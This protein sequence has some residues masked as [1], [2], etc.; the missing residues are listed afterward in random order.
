MYAKDLKIF[1][2]AVFSDICCMNISE[3]VSLLPGSICKLY[4]T[5]NSRGTVLKTKHILR[6]DKILISKDVMAFRCA[7]PVMWTA[8]YVKLRAFQYRAKGTAQRP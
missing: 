4:Q 6:K 8:L 5:S 1:R 3:P 7:S 2:G